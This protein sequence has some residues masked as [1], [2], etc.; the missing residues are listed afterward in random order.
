MNKQAEKKQSKGNKE[1]ANSTNRTKIE[2]LNNTIKI[3]KTQIDALIQ[4]VNQ[5][6]ESQYHD[7]SM[8]KQLVTKKIQEITTV[9]INN[10]LPEINSQA[11]TQNQSK[12]K[13]DFNKK[14]KSKE[15]DGQSSKFR[16]SGSLIDYKG[17]KEI[18]RLNKRYKTNDRE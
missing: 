10:A 14:G 9:E 2:D 1:K 3:L 13:S 16:A 6:V 18:Q 8:Q 5:I 12:M 7:N 15:K 4:L 17:L 11:R